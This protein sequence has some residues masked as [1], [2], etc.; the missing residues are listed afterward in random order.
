MCV[1]VCVCVIIFIYTSLFIHVYLGMWCVKRRDSKNKMEGKIC[2][3]V[4]Q[5]EIKDVSMNVVATLISSCSFQL[6]RIVEK[7]KSEKRKRNQNPLV[8][9]LLTWCVSAALYLWKTRQ[10][11]PPVCLDLNPILIMP[12]NNTWLMATVSTRHLPPLRRVLLRQTISRLVADTDKNRKY[13]KVNFKSASK[14]K[15]KFIY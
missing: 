15:I 11:T 14:L 5:R 3:R 13:V 4:R 9:H 12:G 6:K 2:V 8:Y 10:S 7:K 1:C